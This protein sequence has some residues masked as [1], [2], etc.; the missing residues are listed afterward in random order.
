MTLMLVVNGIML[1][2]MTMLCHLTITS[3]FAP[4]FEAQWP[5]LGWLCLLWKTCEANLNLWLFVLKLAAG[6]EYRDRQCRC[7]V[8]CGQGQIKLLG[9]C[10]KCKWRPSSLT[11]QSLLLPYPHGLSKAGV[12]CLGIFPIILKCWIMTSCI[13][14]WHIGSLDFISI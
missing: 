4:V 11:P 6:T 2:S 9:R 10:A 8:Y 7:T 12:C 1:P 3:H 14:L 13:A 5:R